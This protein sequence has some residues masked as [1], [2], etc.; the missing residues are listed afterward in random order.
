M[1]PEKRICISPST[2]VFF[3]III[4]KSK[5]LLPLIPFVSTLLHELGHIT[6]MYI[7]SQKIQSVTILP[8]GVDIK[9]KPCISSYRADILVSLAGISVN[10]LML[11]LCTLLPK[12]SETELFFAS[13]LILIFI[14]VLPI[15]TLDGGVTLEKTVALHFGSD[16]S[17]R[18]VSVTSAI[19]VFFLGAFS[20]WVLF[21]TG[22]NFTL[23]LMCAYLFGGIFLKKH[24]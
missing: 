18:V 22:Y 20:V 24:R 13:N 6:V 15:K 10:I 19:F 4:I 11:L 2:F 3:T 12:T 9:K 7:F 5:S 14:N 17:E 1:A 8:F 16:L 21:N 23:F